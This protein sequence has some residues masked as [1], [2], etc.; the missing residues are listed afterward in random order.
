MQPDSSGGR[1]GA[2]AERVVVSLSHG[3]FV[4]LYDFTTCPLRTLDARGRSAKHL[5]TRTTTDHIPTEPSAGKSSPCS[6]SSP[7]TPTSR[8]AAPEA[9]VW[10]VVSVA[11]AIVDQSMA[12]HWVPLE[13]VA[14]RYGVWVCMTNKPPTHSRSLIQTSCLPCFVSHAIRPLPDTP[15]LRRKAWKQKG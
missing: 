8:E 5:L 12:P 15:M 10:T 11:G 13:E 9:V 1:K 7:Q 2:Q 14:S 3:I 6:S 4:V